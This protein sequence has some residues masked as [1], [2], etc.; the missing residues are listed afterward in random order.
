[1]GAKSFCVEM[2][3]KLH[4]A[5]SFDAVKELLKLHGLTAMRR[6]PPSIP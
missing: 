6:L 5:L 2:H 1:M 4:I 3:D